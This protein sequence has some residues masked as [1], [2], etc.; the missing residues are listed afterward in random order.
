[1]PLVARTFHRPALRVW[2][3]MLILRI[4]IKPCKAS[5]VD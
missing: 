3:N 2:H 5:V 4:I 1:L